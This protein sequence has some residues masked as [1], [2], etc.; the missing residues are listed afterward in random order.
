MWLLSKYPG[1]LLFWTDVYLNLAGPRKSSGNEHKIKNFRQSECRQLIFLRMCERNKLFW[2]FDWA[3][4]IFVYVLFLFASS[5]LFIHFVVFWCFASGD[6]RTSYF[7]TQT[8]EMW[9]HSQ[10]KSERAKRNPLW[11]LQ[12]IHVIRLFQLSRPR[13]SPVKVS[14]TGYGSRSTSW[15]STSEE[16]TR[17]S[18][19]G[20]R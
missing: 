15:P 8:E 7:V 2:G 10:N 5:S 11:H 6:P 19:E 20:S 17:P 12:F 14:T 1:Y 4:P 16:T 18:T 3:L 9:R 13:W